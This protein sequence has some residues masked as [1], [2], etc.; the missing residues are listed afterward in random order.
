MRIGQN[1]T[2]HAA[3]QQT[4]EPTAT[5]AADKYQG[6][7]VFRGRFDNPVNN[8][9]GLAHTE[10]ALNIRAASDGT[11]RFNRLISALARLSRH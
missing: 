6:A 1:R 10:F 4:C 11:D 3:H 9:I 2:R 7:A 5:M 8:G